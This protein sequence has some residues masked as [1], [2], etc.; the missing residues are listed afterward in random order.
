MPL[1]I[2]N[3]DVNSFTSR[4]NNPGSLNLNSQW[5]R[6][7]MRH[8]IQGSPKELSS[9]SEEIREPVRFHVE[10]S[11]FK[12]LAS[13]AEPI[14]YRRLQRALCRVKNNAWY[15]SV[16]LQQKNISHVET[17]F[18]RMKKPMQELN[19][20]VPTQKTYLYRNYSK[21]VYQTLNSSKSKFIFLT[22]PLKSTDDYIMPLHSEVCPNLDQSPS[23]PILK[24]VMHSITKFEELMCGVTHLS[25]S[26]L[27]TK[28]K[29]SK[30]A[31][32]A[33]TSINHCWLAI[34]SW[35]DCLRNCKAFFLRI[36]RTSHKQ[37]KQH[38]SWRMPINQILFYFIK[39]SMRRVHYGFYK[40][41]LGQIN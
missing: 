19:L 41:I 11:S 25:N 21:M 18:Q 30:L 7:R 26:L 39:S 32:D 13:T 28:D 17:I 3:I 22:N 20:F 9:D 27:L 4:I 6:F 5:N 14:D 24:R 37:M 15:K 31:S 36:S 23:I 38:I 12:K 40:P 2:N 34:M 29:I 1:T 8:S 33:K 10:R 35:D 16:C